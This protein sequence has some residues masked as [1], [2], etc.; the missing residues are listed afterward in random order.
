MGGK[1]ERKEEGEKILGSKIEMKI[2]LGREIKE[3]KIEW[4]I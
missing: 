2:V 1:V 4:K 3:E